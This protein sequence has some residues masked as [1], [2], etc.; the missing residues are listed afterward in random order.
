MGPTRRRQQPCVSAG[1][2]K[3]SQ[4]FF[5]PSS[6]ACTPSPQC[7]AHNAGDTTSSATIDACARYAPRADQQR[8]C[9]SLVPGAGAGNALELKL[10]SGQNGSHVPYAELSAR[11][12]CCASNL[13]SA[14]QLTNYA[15]WPA[16]DPRL[17]TNPSLPLNYCLQSSARAAQIL[18]ALCA[19][20]K[21][22]PA[23]HTVQQQQEEHSGGKQNGPAAGPSSARSA[24]ILAALQAKAGSPQGQS[25]VGPAAPVLSS[26]L[27][28]AA[29]SAASPKGVAPLLNSE[30]GDQAPDVCRSM[31]DQW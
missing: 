22:H 1:A 17:W 28:H 6:C 5:E 3:G 31:R 12:H 8:V 13:L 21:G 2:E 26:A 11:F 14:D 29:A 10:T 9:V 25:P 7:S 19:S 27:V 18:A 30:A 4:A 24:K 23:Q 16:N 20:S 15:H